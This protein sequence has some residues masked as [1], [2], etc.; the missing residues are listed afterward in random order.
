MKFNR[1]ETYSFSRP[2]TIG[3]MSI[4]PVYV[5]ME[6][7]HTSIPAHQHSVTSYEIHYCKS[8]R[9][10]LLIGE[11]TWDVERGTIYVTGPRIIHEQLNSVSD[12]IIE[13]CLFL[14][15]K[16]IEASNSSS[17]S[18]LFADTHFWIGNDPGCLCPILE[19][20]LAE[21]RNPRIDTAE[22]TEVLLRQ[23]I[24]MLT[25]LYRENIMASK[26]NSC[27]PAN[28]SINYIPLIDDVFCYQCS[29]L[30]L[31]QL[32]NMLNLSVRQTQ[33]L[34][35]KSFGKTFSQKLTEA[36]M[37]AASQLLL[38][39]DFTVTKISEQLGFS[40]MEY[41]SSSFH[42]FMNCSPR[43][44]RKKLNDKRQREEPSKPSI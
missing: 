19:Q 15:C 33:R 18:K 7:L 3:E 38:N 14:E 20:I 43:D 36:R 16:C 25:R 44:Y 23:F 29:N 17:N 40:C 26:Q 21:N 39:T 30:T 35:R 31:S 34:L 24:A 4:L 10:K 41:F 37:A 1:M 42:R 8:G 6:Q 11:H 27:T 13:Y 9:G 22:I 2:F 5:R 12:P 32:A 28:T